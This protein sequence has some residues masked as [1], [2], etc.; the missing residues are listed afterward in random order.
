ML[1]DVAEKSTLDHLL[2]AHRWH[3]REHS[4]GLRQLDI[5]EATH[6]RSRR[7]SALLVE[8]DCLLLRTAG[9]LL[10]MLGVHLVEHLTC[11][12][13]QCLAGGDRLDD[14]SYRLGAACDGGRR[15]SATP[16]FVG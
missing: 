16:P 15:R 11:E 10:G 14:V 7:R 3:P 1:V 9:E 12:V 13:W 4:A 2:G 6:G 5:G 8:R